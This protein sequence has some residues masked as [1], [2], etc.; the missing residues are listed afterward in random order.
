[1]LSPDPSTVPVPLLCSEE[2][3]FSI[4]WLRLFFTLL[5]VVSLF[6][7]GRHIWYSF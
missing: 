2:W 5:P 3:R 1:M 7:D 6:H 4:E